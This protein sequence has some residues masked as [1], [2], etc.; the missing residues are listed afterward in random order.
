VTCSCKYKG[1]GTTIFITLTRYCD[2]IPH[3]QESTNVIY[4]EPGVPNKT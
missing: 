4:C 1:P 3:P 2:L